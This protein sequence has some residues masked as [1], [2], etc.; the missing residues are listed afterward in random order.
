M[1][2]KD[3]NNNNMKNY[4]FTCESSNT[5]LVFAALLTIGMITLFI[6][7]TRN[8]LTNGIITSMAIILA[9]LIFFGGLLLFD[10]KNVMKNN[11]DNV[12]Y[13]TFAFVLLFINILINVIAMVWFMSIFFPPEIIKK[14]NNKDVFLYINNPLIGFFGVLCIYLFFNYYIYSQLKCG[15]T[16]IPILIFLLL[17]FAFTECI[18]QIL[19]LI[20]INNYLHKITDG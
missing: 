4:I 5:V 8:V 3:A 9:S 12:P 13:S 17:F 2:T 20:M 11:K 18:I 16:Y 19:L 14:I 1:S 7:F 10:I 15:A 6:E